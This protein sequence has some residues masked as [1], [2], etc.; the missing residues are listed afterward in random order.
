[1][2]CQQWA[3]YNQTPGDRIEYETE[4]ASMVSL[5]VVCIYIGSYLMSLGDGSVEEPAEDLILLWKLTNEKIFYRSAKIKVCYKP[6]AGEWKIW[7][8]FS[9]L[10]NPVIIIFDWLCFGG[11]QLHKVL[12]GTVIEYKMTSIF[13]ES[14]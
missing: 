4:A 12:L 8:P 14:V 10:C 9:K 7:L 2:P 13:E 1:M 6:W 3:F 11:N 5:I